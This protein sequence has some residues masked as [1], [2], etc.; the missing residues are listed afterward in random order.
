MILTLL[1]EAT[2]RNVRWKLVFDI[3]SHI[4]SILLVVFLAMPAAAFV[5]LNT[6][7]TIVPTVGRVRYA[8]YPSSLVSIC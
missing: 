2:P 6:N 4:F 5:T 8:Y 7:I 1:H 3:E